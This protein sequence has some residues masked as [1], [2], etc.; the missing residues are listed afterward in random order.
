MK[1]LVL[2]V[3]FII[4]GCSEMTI[5]GEKNCELSFLLSGE[6]VTADMPIT[7]SLN[8]N[9]LLFVQVYRGNDAFACGIFDNLESMKLNLKQGSDKYRMIFSL[10]KNGK[11]LLG[12]FNSPGWAI[13]MPHYRSSHNAFLTGENQEFYYI[14]GSSTREY[15][16]INEFW[17][18]SV[19][20]YNYYNA[21]SNA[22]SNGIGGELIQG[23]RS[24]SLPNIG[25]SSSYRNNGYS[26]NVLVPLLC[27][28]WFYGEIADYSPIGTSDILYIDLLRTGFKFMY[29]V[30]GVTDGQVDISISQL[31]TS[32]IS[33][34]TYS[35]DV[36]F[37]A[38]NNVRNAWLYA[39][40]YSQDFTVS[41]VWHRGI[42]VTQDLGSKTI[43]IKRNCL[44]NIKINLGSNDQSA[45]MNLTVEA[46]STIGAEAVTIPV[47]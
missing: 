37:Y 39:D 22:G 18:N 12:N 14:D 47:Q 33:S 30:S 1:R 11:S 7:K 9:D 46:E 34:S 40:N 29:E 25:T 20:D 41:V 32:T 38:F 2:I 10:V 26:Q 19:K 16:V 6:I 23:S 42:G 5:N 31:V 8:S 4:V 3:S 21:G 13:E 17:Y 36:C 15:M 28:D 24:L 45:G 27:D 35:S 43:Q 44:N